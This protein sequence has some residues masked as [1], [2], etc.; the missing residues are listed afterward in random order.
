MS[1]EICLSFIVTFL[2]SLA[3]VPIVG[4]ISK[5]LRKVKAGG[6]ERNGAT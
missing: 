6:S 4:K 1:L 2:I 5:K 3:L